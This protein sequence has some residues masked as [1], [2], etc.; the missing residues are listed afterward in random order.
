M[1]YSFRVTQQSD[2]EQ[3][4]GFCLNKTELFYFFP[5]AAYPLTLEQLRKQFSRRHES[6]VMLEDERIVV[7]ANF[8]N[9]AK[10]NIA[11]IGNVIIRPDKRS[12][13]LGQKLLRQ[14][15]NNGFTKLQLKEVHLSCYQNNLSAL[16]LYK[17]TGFKAYAI[18][19]RP[20]LNKQQT[21]L[22]H[23]RIRNT[24]Y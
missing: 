17:K 16:S 20:D 3:I 19:E 15:I 4:A 21:R 11:F 12:L 24:G 9:V 10:Y 5:S 8:Y 18:E 13:G 7:F 1:G 14:M 6:I 22:M 2:L 23:M